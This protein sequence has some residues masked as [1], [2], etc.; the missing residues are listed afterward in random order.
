MKKRFSKSSCQPRRTLKEGVKNNTWVFRSPISPDTLYYI[1]FMDS[2]LT[3][4]FLPKTMTFP[5]VCSFLNLHSTRFCPFSP[6]SVMLRRATVGL[7]APINRQ[8]KKKRLT[9]LLYQIINNKKRNIVRWLWFAV[10][11]LHWR[12]FRDDQNC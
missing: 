12:G 5:R 11:A 7:A 10:N 8:E 1:L 6:G 9:M 2:A 4:S 3:L